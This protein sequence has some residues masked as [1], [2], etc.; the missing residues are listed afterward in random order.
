[1]SCGMS[2]MLRWKS[3][4][5]WLCELKITLLVLMLCFT[6]LFRKIWK[7]TFY[8]KKINNQGYFNSFTHPKISVIF[9]DNFISYPNSPSPVLHFQ[10]S[11][12]LWCLLWMK[13]KWQHSLYIFSPTQHTKFTIFLVISIQKTDIAWK[14][15]HNF[16]MS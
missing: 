6:T 14:Y 12:W 16:K 8:L 5:K 10:H 2:S 3:Y 15:S 9:S 1:M 13:L 4:V 7:L 11:S